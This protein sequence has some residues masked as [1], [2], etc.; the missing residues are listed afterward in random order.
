MHR[1]PKIKALLEQDVQAAMDGDPSL[2]SIEEAVL[3]YP[4]IE[5]VTCYRIAHELHQ[6][7]AP[8][9]P[10]MIMAHAQSLTGIDIHP[11]ARIGR[12]FFIDHG[13][14]VVIG[15]TAIIGDD[16]RLYQGV[17]LGAKSFPVDHN[18]RLVK[19][20]PRHPILEDGVVVYSGASILGRITIGRNAVIGGGVWVTRDVAP[21]TSVTQAKPRQVDFA[22]GGG[23]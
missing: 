7:G 21:A 5:A 3:C 17:T 23:I 12:R 16:V 2:Y 13:S 6:L 10:R 8:F 19:G 1:L 20:Q 4:G 11:G 22:D 9:L 14:G 15:G 18:G